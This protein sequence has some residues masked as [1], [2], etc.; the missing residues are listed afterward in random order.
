MVANT[1]VLRDHL[2]RIG[3]WRLVVANAVMPSY[4]AE[5]IKARGYYVSPA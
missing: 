4:A 3:D 1:G 5:G 2:V